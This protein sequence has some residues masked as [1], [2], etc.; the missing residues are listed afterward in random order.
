MTQ[1]DIDL[2]HRFVDNG[3]DVFRRADLMFLPHPNMAAEMRDDSRQPEDDWLPWKEVASTVTDDD[4]RALEQVA[5]RR[6]PALYGQFLKYKHFYQLAPVKEISFLSHGIHEWKDGLIDYYT[7]YDD[8]TEIIGKGYI[9]FADY[10]DYGPVCFNTSKQTDLDNDCEVVMFDHEDIFNGPN[11]L[12][13][14]F[15][16]MMRD[17]VATQE[18]I[19]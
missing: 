6:L 3:I 2:I 10:S 14:S 12:Y 18:A 17:L 1:A 5:G 13:P 4:I 8:P 19:N 11:V 9:P 16:E 7:S 15:A